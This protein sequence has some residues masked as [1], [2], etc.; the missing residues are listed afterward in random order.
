MVLVIPS[1]YSGVLNISI[2][3]QKGKAKQMAFKRA[4]REQVW[5]KVLLTGPSGG[6]KS[7]S[8]LKLATGIYSKCGG[9][10]IAYIGT[11]GSRDKYY[12]DKYEYDLIQLDKTGDSRKFEDTSPESYIHQIDEAINGGYKILVID[13]MTPEWIYINEVHDAMKGNSF[14]NW[15]K[16]KPRHTKFME[17]ILMS[18][19]H[20]IC[21]ARGKDAWVMEDQNG[22]QVPRK[23]G[24]GGQTDKDVSYS[25][26]VSLLLNDQDKH[27]FE[28]D[29]DNTGLFDGVYGRAIT[30][31]DGEDLFYW[32]NDSDIPAPAI[33]KKYE[34]A[35]ISGDDK[36]KSLKQEIIK[37]YA[38]KE[39][40]TGSPEVQV[41][42]LTY[43]IND[44]NEHLK[45]HKKDHHSRRGLLK[46]VGQ[47]RNMLAY[48]KKKD[49]N[50][51]R[52]L[53]EQLGLR[54]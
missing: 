5:L 16:V 40:D 4:I 34:K 22:K 52:T 45:V 54:K 6:G 29:K 51:Y 13:T 53:I 50:R 28:C 24:M 11:E 2:G 8:A 35:E 9:E 21:C 14:T 23:V 30:E 3:K 25:M 10:G 20:I 1:A 47:R 39:G 46:M 12:A 15:G 43:R 26:A 38:I 18:P 7:T 49:I 17:K 41:A 44:L 48:L 32:A 37:E 27:T 19:I 31:K 36:L 42:I 33:E